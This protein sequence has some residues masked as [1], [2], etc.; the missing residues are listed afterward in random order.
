MKKFQKTLILAYEANSAASLNCI[1]F[2]FLTHCVVLTLSECLATLQGT[3]EKLLYFLVNNDL[4][5]IFREIRF[6]QNPVI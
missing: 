3:N 1:F 4:N 2:G 5:L 6:V